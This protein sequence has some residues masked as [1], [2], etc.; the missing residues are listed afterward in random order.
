MQGEIL[1]FGRP[2]TLLDGNRHILLETNLK[3]PLYEYLRNKGDIIDSRIIPPVYLGENV[4][5]KRSVIG[6]NVSIGDD[7]E[8][9]KSIISESVIGDK[10]ILRKLI[11]SDSIIGDYAILEDLIKKN[12]TIGDSSLITTSNKSF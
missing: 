6:P 1:D 3:D 7:L 9:E 12:I 5:I 11:T 2:E 4:K 8:I 10:V